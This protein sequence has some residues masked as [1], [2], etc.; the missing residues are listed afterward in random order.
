VK[1]VTDSLCQLKTQIINADLS[2]Y[3]ASI[4][5]VRLMAVIAER[6]ADGGVLALIQHW[7]KAPVIEERTSSGLGLARAA[8]AL[9]CT[10]QRRSA[11]LAA[12]HHHESGSARRAA[13]V[14][15]RVLGWRLGV[16]DGRPSSARFRQAREAERQEPGSAD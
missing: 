2:K 10:V 6:I 9:L 13:Q 7:L 4:P 3:F 8:P 5:H 14:W 11:L 15:R 1:A 16:R 12:S